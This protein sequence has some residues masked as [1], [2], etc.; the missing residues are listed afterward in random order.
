M[1]IERVPTGIPGLD[2]LI[3]GGLPKGSITLVT[4]PS[5]SGKTTLGIQFLYNGITKFGENGLFVTLEEEVSDLTRDMTRYGWELK[6]LAD[7]GKFGIT[8]SPIPFELS[9]GKVNLDNLMDNI[10][11]QAM[12]V[13]ARRIVFD[14]IAS[15]GLP[16]D[17]PVGLRRD[18]LRLG[19][20]L[21][22]LGCTTLLLTEMLEGE[23]KVTRYGIEQFV[24]H[25]VIA[26]QVTP[27]YRSL[28][29]MKMR[30]TK[31]NMGIHRL[32]ITDEGLVIT[33]G[34]RP[35]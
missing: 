22:E 28:Q 34:E 14:S 6:E 12:S 30:G 13:D 25:G 27:N 11:Q 33:P 17:D 18:V 8:H 20:L 7:Q 3:E 10:H 35:F 15:L 21:R 1:K 29:V 19:A 24:T 32:C 4:G 26:L 31:H 23:A 9:E 5:G 16:Y 2:G